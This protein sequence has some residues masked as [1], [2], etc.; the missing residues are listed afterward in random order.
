MAKLSVD[1]GGTF[2]PVL[3][4]SPNPG[5]YGDPGNG[6]KIYDDSLRSEGKPQIYAVEYKHIPEQIAEC[7]ESKWNNKY[8]L[9]GN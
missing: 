7:F 3:P 9:V 8:V 6:R 5:H 1:T 2:C 4:V